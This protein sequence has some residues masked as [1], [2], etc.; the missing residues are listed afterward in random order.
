MTGTT[1]LQP[2]E[3]VPRY[4]GRLHQFAFFV[5][6]PAGVFVTTVAPTLSTRIA[7]ALF[8]FG[9]AGMFGASAAYHRIQWEPIARSRIRRLD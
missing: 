8:A 9:V 4:R 6:I 7:A 3:V 1:T 5:A 2:S